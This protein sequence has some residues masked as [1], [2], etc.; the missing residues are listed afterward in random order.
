MP[1]HQQAAIEAAEKKIVQAI[2]GFVR[3]HKTI[4][5]EE[6]TKDVLTAALPA[7]EKQIREQVAADIWEYWPF[8]RAARYRE[9]ACH[10][11]GEYRQAPRQGC[12]VK[13]PATI[14]KELTMP[15]HQQAALTA[16]QDEIYRQLNCQY[17]DFKTPS[18]EEVKAILAAAEPHLRKKWAEEL[19]ERIG[20]SNLGAPLRIDPDGTFRMANGPEMRALL[21]EFILEGAGE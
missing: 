7:I 6:L 15:D 21:C 14:A 4:S 13:T 9:A 16:M 1:D 12:G 18:D 11:T 2:T 19:V 17:G 5:S 20:A 8:R 3:E 10:S